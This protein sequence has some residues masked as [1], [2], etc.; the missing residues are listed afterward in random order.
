MELRLLGPVELVV[1]GQ[2]VDAGTS[3]QRAVLAALAVDVG[4]PV[5]ADKLIDRVWG[6][7][8]PSRARH[9]LFVYLSRL[10]AVLRRIPS[11][12]EAWAAIERRSGGYVLQIDPASVDLHRFRELLRLAQTPSHNTEQR[13][14]LLG[15]ALALWRGDPLADVPGG[16]A[17]GVRQGLAQQRIDTVTE[18]ATASVLLGEAATAIQPMLELIT[19]E[20]FN[21]Y[22]VAILMRALHSHG[23]TGDALRVYAATRD[24]LVTELGID[25]GPELQKVHLEILRGTPS[26]PAQPSTPATLV[27]EPRPAQLPPDI[28]WFIGRRSEILAMDRLLAGAPGHP[29]AVNVA[30]VS[31]TAGVGKSALAVH[32]AHRVADKF[33][34]GQLY[35]NLRGFDADGPAMTPHQAVRTVLDALHVPADQVPRNPDA[36]IGLYRSLLAGR[37]MLVVL[38][39]ASDAEQVRPLLPG[40]SRCHVVVTSRNKLSGLV[41]IESA[42]PVVLDLLTPAETW[43]LFTRRLGVDRVRAEPSAVEQIIARCARLPLALA[44]VAAR[45]ATRP[46]VSLKVLADELGRAP[47]ELDAF[48]DGDQTIDLRSVFFWSYRGLASAAARL[49]RLLG[50]H[51]GP[52]ANIDAITSLAG[53]PPEQIQ[54]LLNDL[55][56]ANLV[57]E[58]ADR[59]YSLHDLLRAYAAEL[60][61][62]EECHVQRDPAVKRLLDHYLH[63]AYR[64]DRHVRPGRQRLELAPPPPDVQVGPITGAQGANAWFITEHQVLLRVLDQAAATGADERLWRLAWTL[65][66]FFEGQGHWYDWM[67]TQRAALAAARRLGD[68]VARAHAHRGLALA[69]ARLGRHAEAQ[70]HLDA[71]LGLFADLGDTIG[72]AHTHRNLA[73]LLEREGRPQE[74]LQQA[75]HALRLFEATG[76]QEGRARALNMV[77]W[78]HAKTGDFRRALDY[79][80]RALPLLR[81]LGNRA[82]EGHTADSIGF[83]LYHL[84]Y[85]ERALTHFHRA[86]RLFKETKNRHPQADTLAHLAA[87]HDAMGNAS[88][89]H[90][91]LQQ[92]LRLLEELG[93]PDV[94]DI[95]ARVHRLSAP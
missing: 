64:A 2:P 75:Q 95:R 44:I 6:E 45:A 34:D 3:R 18:W 33:P 81:R 69:V 82:A 8:S 87:V 36:Q 7:T 88:A 24:R 22:L 25:P 23:R 35:I 32:W 1:A 50:L 29:V 79:C 11:A 42:H 78:Y 4:Q 31:G 19:E 70:D 83:A 67:N 84:G 49:F 80:E 62:A 52:S 72:Q 63:T 17:A 37:R 38:D 41:V 68:H 27:L 48:S 12:D 51:P 46:A 5:S 85:H 57:A 28:R 20:P 47:H 60:V 89:A 94:Q 76:D 13:R 40:A 91:A 66:N 56:H 43:R 16:W 74:A 61:Q 71:A 9:V 15:D 54:P 10:R 90:K 65:E 59:R 14:A 39:N 77:G 86:L 58:I 30:V 55:I 92:A 93:S 21:E 73:Y 26:P 53:L